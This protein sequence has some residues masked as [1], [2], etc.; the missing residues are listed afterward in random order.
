MF[1]R[2]GYDGFVQLHHHCQVGTLVFNSHHTTDNAL[3]QLCN[4]FIVN[5]TLVGSSPVGPV[6]L[7][8]AM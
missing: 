1:Q 4:C 2:Y 5:G 7:A 3:T 6:S 8:L